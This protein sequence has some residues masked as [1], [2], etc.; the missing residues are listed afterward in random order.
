[1]ISKVG[2]GGDDEAGDVAAAV[3]Q[4]R[5]NDEIVHLGAEAGE[6]FE[7]VDA[8]GVLA[9]L[10]DRF[11]GGF[12]QSAATGAAQVGLG[13]DGVNERPLFNGVAADLGEER[14]GPAAAAILGGDVFESF[15]NAPYDLNVHHK[16]ER[17]AAVALRQCLHSQRRFEQIGAP[18]A[19][20]L[21]DNQGRKTRPPDVNE[22]FV[23]KCSVAVM[24]GSP[25]AQDGDQ[26]AC[27]FD[28]ALQAFSSRVEHSASETAVVRAASGYRSLFTMSR[29][30]SGHWF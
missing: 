11:G 24:L 9:I 7:P 22:V 16:A 21:R 27:D 3:L 30:I 20:L 14:L 25:L 12:G 4:G 29:G 18:A 26:A 23:W 8:P 6:G 1:M 28:E 10:P 19:E 15:G 5:G 13:G 17:S 2:A